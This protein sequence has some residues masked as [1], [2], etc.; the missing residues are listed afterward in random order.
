MPFHARDTSDRAED[1]IGI[2]SPNVKSC[3]LKLLGRLLVVPGDSYSFRLGSCFDLYFLHNYGDRKASFQ[4]EI[5]HCVFHPHSTVV[6]RKARPGPGAI[7]FRSRSALGKRVEFAPRSVG[8]LH[9][10]DALCCLLEPGHLPS[11]WRRQGT[12]TAF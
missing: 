9:W 7:C 10:T 2:Q 5:S 11:V 1:I 3:T 4:R 6:V 12:G 8:R